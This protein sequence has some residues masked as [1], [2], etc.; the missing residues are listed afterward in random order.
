[1][2]N[3]LTKNLF[4]QRLNQLRKELGLNQKQLAEALQMNNR[5]LNHYE[6]GLREPDF[7]MLIM[8][9][10][11]FNVSTDYLLGRTENREISNEKTC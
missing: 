11:F 1:M 10:D 4:G 9:A 2:M 6:T 3:K 7:D 5:T 8:F